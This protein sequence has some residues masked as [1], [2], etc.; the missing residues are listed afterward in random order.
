[1]E[2][3][4]SRKKSREK[5]MGILFGMEI[6]KDTPAEAIETSIDNF[7][8]DVEE[9]DLDYISEVLEGIN[10]NKA[11]IDSII[12]DNLKNWKLERISKVNLTILRLGIYEIK[13][14]EDVPGKVALNEAL[15][16]GKIYSDQKGVAFI[17]GVLDK[18]LKEV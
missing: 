11:E 9:L 5:A 4:M 17:N 12:K 7:E 10:N 16:L 8:G 13:Y 1:L 6:S 2:E 15:E 14:L 18:V 3:N